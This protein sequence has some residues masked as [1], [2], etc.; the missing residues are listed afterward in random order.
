MTSSVWGLLGE[1]VAPE[2]YTYGNVRK[3][4]DTGLE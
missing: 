1:N 2:G 4:L 3:Q